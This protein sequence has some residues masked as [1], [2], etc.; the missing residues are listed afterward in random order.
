MT[1]LLNEKRKFYQILM[2]LQNIFRKMQ[3]H[4]IFK[5]LIEISTSKIS[6]RVFFLISCTRYSANSAFRIE[7]IKSH[8][9]SFENLP[10]S[11]NWLTDTKKI[12]FSHF[13]QLDAMIHWFWLVYWHLNIIKLCSRDMKSIYLDIINNCS[14]SEE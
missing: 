8:N 9:S 14:Q 5:S 2:K 4:E 12:F 3:K 10:N 6:L 11:Q 13:L 7:S 1:N